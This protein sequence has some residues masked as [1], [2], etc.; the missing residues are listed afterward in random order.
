M[1][2]CSIS[3]KNA[4]VS[5]PSAVFNARTL[6]HVVFELMRFQKP[7]KRLDNVH[8]IKNFSI[9]LKSGDRL[10]VIGLNGAGKS[11]LLRMIAKLYPTRTGTVEVQGAIRALFDISLGFEIEAT[12]RENI[13]YRGLMM[14]ETP[15]AMHAREQE[16]IDFANLNEFI[17]YPI[18][19]Y[20]TGMLVRLAFAISTAVDG[21]ILL[22]DEML[23]AGDASFAEKAR[24]RMLEMVER[25]NIMV[26]VSH[27]MNTIRRVCTRCILMNHG[28]ILLDGSPDDVVQSYLELI[29]KGALQ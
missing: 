4:N 11:T 24:H 14:G 17:D 7:R 5:Y 12:G 1:R 15:S 23:G 28:E 19:S 21:D 13:M 10:G 29:A 22:L 27:D 6:K 25:S 16:I 9:E 2:E 8:A 20:S 26:L 3:I 18:K